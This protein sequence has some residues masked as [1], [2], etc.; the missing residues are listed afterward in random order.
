[1]NYLF[2]EN[3]ADG[4]VRLALEHPPG[5]ITLLIEIKPDYVAAC[6][7]AMMQPRVNFGPVRIPVVVQEVDAWTF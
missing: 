6:Q 5:K 2:V 7:V 3:R 1:M 4:G